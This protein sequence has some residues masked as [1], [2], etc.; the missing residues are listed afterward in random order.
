VL[1]FFAGMEKV[2][3]VVTSLLST[4]E[5]LVAVLLGAFFLGERLSLLQGVGGL[6]ILTAVIL[7]ARP[8]RPVAVTRPS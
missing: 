4:V 1:T 2:G 7:L 6:L 3:P 8:E 5:P